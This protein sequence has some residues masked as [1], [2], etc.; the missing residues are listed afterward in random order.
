MHSP[1][2]NADKDMTNNTVAKSTLEPP[3]DKLALVA[4][5]SWTAKIELPEY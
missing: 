4:K 5:P 3:N 2:K 1:L